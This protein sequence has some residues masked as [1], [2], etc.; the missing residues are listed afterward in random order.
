MGVAQHHPAQPTSAGHIGRQ[1]YGHRPGDGLS[2]MGAAPP[3]QIV[4]KPALRQ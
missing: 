1:S 2:P 4:G 3:S